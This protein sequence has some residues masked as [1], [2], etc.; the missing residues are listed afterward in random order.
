[1]LSFERKA[2][3]DAIQRGWIFEGNDLHFPDWEVK[4]GYERSIANLFFEGWKEASQ[5]DQDEFLVIMI[6]KFGN[7]L[8]A[9]RLTWEEAIYGRVEDLIFNQMEYV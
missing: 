7:H 5:F 9:K 3:Q 6:E 1:M 4:A 2:M 8:M